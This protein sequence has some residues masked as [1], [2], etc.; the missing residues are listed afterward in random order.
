MSSYDGYQHWPQASTSNA[1]EDELSSPEIEQDD[2][3]DNTESSTSSTSTSATSS[4]S[5]SGS[6]SGSSQSGSDSESTSTADEDESSSLK[7]EIAVANKTELVLPTGVCEDEEVFKQLFS[8]NSWVCLSDQQKEHLKSFLPTFPENDL[9][10]K[11]ITL[12]MLFG[13]Q[14]F[15][16]GENPINDFHDKLKNGHFLP[17]TVKLKSLLRRSLKR[18]YR[19]NQRIYHYNMLLKL[20][21]GRK[22]VIDDLN[23]LPTMST[24]T[25]G[26]SNSFAMHQQVRRRY[27]RELSD[28]KQKVGDDSEDSSDSNYQEGPPARLS[29]KQRKHLDAVQNSLATEL[30]TVTS[31]LATYPEGIDLSKVVFPMSNPIEPTEDMYREMLVSHKRKLKKIEQDQNELSVRLFNDSIKSSSALPLTSEKKRS[32]TSERPRAK[33]PKL[34]KQSPLPS[35]AVKTEEIQTKPIKQSSPGLAP[36]EPINNV[37]P[38]VKLEVKEE[39]PPE[40]TSPPRQLTPPPPPLSMP[41]P[42]TPPPPHHHHHHH[43]PQLPQPPS[44]L[45][46]VPEVIK[47]ELLTEDNL[48]TLKL[49]SCI[50]SIQNRDLVKI[51]QVI[52]NNK[53]VEAV[54]LTADEIRKAEE[55]QAAAA[56]LLEQMS[57]VEE[58]YN[59]PVSPSPPLK[60]ITENHQ[61]CPSNYS[62]KR[63]FHPEDMLTTT[64]QTINT[65]SPPR[66]LPSCIRALTPNDY[67]SK[68]LS[69]SPVSTPSKVVTD[70]NY[71]G[72]L[73]ELEGF[74]VLDIKSECNEDLGIK[75]LPEMEKVALSFFALIR[76]IICSNWEYRMNMSSIMKHVQNWTSSLTDE[77]KN[78]VWFQYLEQKT[79]SNALQSAIGFLAG[80]FPEWQPEDFVPFIEYKPNLDT[81]Q[82][83][84]AGRDS[85]N[86]L[87]ELC[88][89]WLL[90]LNSINSKLNGPREDVIPDKKIPIAPAVDIP[91]L[92]LSETDSSLPPTTPLDAWIVTPSNSDQR[93]IFQSQ[94]RQRFLKPHRS[95]VYL[96]HGYESVVGPV[97]GIYNSSNIHKAARGHSLLIENRPHFISILVLVRDATARLPNGMG[98]RG[99]ICTLLKDSQYLMEVNQ[100]E[101][102]NAVSGA[103]DRLHYEHDPCV[104]YDPK[105][106]IW[107][108]LHRGRSVEE[109]ERLH[110]EQQGAVKTKCWRRSKPV[111]KSPEP[112]VTTANQKSL[113][114]AFTDSLSMLD[115]PTSSTSDSL[116]SSSTSP[117]MCDLAVS[118]AE[119]VVT[120]SEG[121][122][123][124]NV[125]VSKPPK[126]I[127][128]RKAPMQTTQT[129]QTPDNIAHDIS[130]E[131][132]A[133]NRNNAEIHQRLSVPSASGIAT[134]AT[135]SANNLVTAVSSNAGSVSSM[136]AITTS[137]NIK[138]A[139][140]QTVVVNNGQI[141][142]INQ[143]VSSN[144]Q[145]IVHSRQ[146]VANNLT[147]KHAISSGDFIAISPRKKAVKNVQ[148]TQ[149]LTIGTTSGSTNFQHDHLSIAKPPQNKEPQR[150]ILVLKQK[151]SDQTDQAVSEHRGNIQISQ[152]DAIAK[153]QPIQQLIQLQQQQQKLQKQQQQMQQLKLLQHKQ[154]Q[155]QVLQHN[156]QQV[157]IKKSEVDDKAESGDGG[158]H[159]QVIFV[160]QG[161]RGNHSEPQQITQQ[162]LQQLLMRSQQQTGQQTQVVMVKQQG[163]EQKSIA[164]KPI[165]TSLHGTKVQQ[166][167]PKATANMLL[168]ATKQTGQT[169]QR[170]IAKPFVGKFLSNP[171]AQLPVE[172]VLANRKLTGV[173]QGTSLRISGV[174][175]SKGAQP[176]YT[177][178]TVAQPKLMPSNQ[179]TIGQQMP[180]RL[181][182]INE[183]LKP[184]VDTSQPQT[185]RVVQS[186]IGGKSLIVTNKGQPTSPL[187]S[188]SSSANMVN[189]AVVNSTA[190]T[191]TVLQQGSQQILVPA[192]SLK[193]IQGLKVIPLAQHGVKG[194]SQ[195]FA[196]IVNPD[197]VRPVFIQQQSSSQDSGQCPSKSNS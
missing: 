27:F 60:K 101:L 29:K 182:S 59:P 25:V 162:Q 163:N 46:L 16:F 185:L 178:V 164:L 145:T 139:N 91:T 128:G 159:P 39:S 24:N 92:E 123:K 160:K 71:V 99:D 51:E 81:Y 113:S 187:T 7:T 153:H 180:T 130:L 79:W 193:S 158:E 174:Q 131:C 169:V 87:G 68:H 114:T 157:I 188:V 52:E 41:L 176:Q 171:R 124:P 119:E 170:R 97:R 19:R 195:M 183:R 36:A 53:P 75:P 129:V 84:G 3:D 110:L 107:I 106:K 146:V 133:A 21:S 192:G 189:S 37:V 152:F 197:N 33:R 144:N 70:S 104:K 179:L 173:S 142:N 95:F 141:I 117:V 62:V 40:P 1:D 116:P 90:N 143:T 42:L 56:M 109:F 120:S 30:D 121:I 66:M 105:R 94:E 172:T 15:R 47:E 55:G 32:A 11:E 34:S 161:L 147:Q 80:H 67:N 6:S 177:V 191:Y 118:V 14:S 22:K 20:V 54:K 4:G 150:Q 77:V 126:I 115:C 132:S 111:K 64:V 26:G 12:R 125:V 13:G 31:T 149:P 65:D 44:S 194:R 165:L 140:T 63:E 58:K 168:Q 138:I 76:D 148:L 112:K 10:E 181:T 83:I 18:E 167:T 135:T 127:R 57:D 45:P 166:N 48:S 93:A 137:G 5:T 190:N 184:N 102:H 49:E 72:A 122:R 100:S 103:L 2:S 28:I 38:F 74:H 134:A 89:C 73:S 50:S 43:P 88:R 96:M 78:P 175:T 23:G 186:Q 108:Y 156:K 154:L 17:D 61:F 8:V 86:R 196:R 69:L 136:P 155:Q 98:T 85:D 9:M 82:W 151:R 35:T